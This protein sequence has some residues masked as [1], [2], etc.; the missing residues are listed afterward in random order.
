MIRIKYKRSGDYL[1]SVKNYS[2]LTQRTLLYVAIN[3]KTYHV[4]LFDESQPRDPNLFGSFI[5]S[6]SYVGSSLIDAK[7]KAKKL[8]LNTGVKFDVEV[9][10]KT[11]T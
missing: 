7:K 6:F 5:P 1:L 2:T 3:L 8:L 11:K 10:N 4:Y 9:R